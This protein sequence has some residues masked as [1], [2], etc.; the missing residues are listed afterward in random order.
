MSR[1][2][3]VALTM[4]GAAL[5][6]LAGGGLAYQSQDNLDGFL[7]VTAL[8]AAVYLTAVLFAWRGGSSRLV[9]LGIAAVALLMRVPVALAP[10][11]LSSDIYRYIW[12]GRIEAAGF[13]PYTHEPVDPRLQALRDQD[14][15][16]QI[17]SKQAPTIYPPVAETIFLAVTRVSESVTAM[18]VTMVAFETVTFAF[19][20]RLLA[21]EGLPTTRVIVY[22]WHPLPLWE[23]AGSGHIDAVLIAFCAGAL[24][25]ARRGRDGLSGVFLAGATLT[26]FYPVVL[27]AAL[28]RRWDWKLPAAFALAMII[29]Y[30]PFITAGSQVFGFLPGYAG[31][32]GL[33]A[34]GAGFYLLGV[35][36]LLLPPAALSARAYIIGA[37]AI[38]AVLGI[39]LVFRRYGT[40]PSIAA[41]G[42]LATVFTVLVSPHYPWYFAWLIV[43]AC[44]VQS[45]ALL[46]LTNACMLL[47]LSAGY[48]F[49]H[50]DQR[51]AIGSIIYGPF[52]ALMLVDLRRHRRRAIPRS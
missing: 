40:R 44:F 39:A 38:L 47:Y 15:F 11:Y 50:N 24:W 33:N 43:F 9:V 18:K 25:A 37:G 21:I 30:L 2:R 14:I 35:L 41:A 16:P 34:N 42:A 48:L 1:G 28:Y 4:A 13:N 6:A 20:A 3:L 17:A 8:Q 23:F 49:V 19:L 29:G 32:E 31:Q 27:L 12:D 5:L 10:P 45:F 46:W 36:R 51:L 26:K 52:A 7:A 22:A